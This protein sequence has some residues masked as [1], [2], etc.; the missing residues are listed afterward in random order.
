VVSADIVEALGWVC[1][2]SLAHMHVDDVWRDL[3]QGAGCLAYVP[4]VVIEHLHPDAGKA[5]TDSTY[6]GSL[7]TAGADREAYERW[8]REGM[9]GDVAK[10]RALRERAA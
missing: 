10:I 6:A 7:A 2:P 9:T 4:S 1:E 3:G 8:R 5:A